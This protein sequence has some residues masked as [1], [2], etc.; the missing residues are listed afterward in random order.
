[1]KSILSLAT[2]LIVIAAYPAL[3]ERNL[4]PTIDSVSNI[5]P[6]RPEEPQ[7]MQEISIRDAYQ[8]VLVQD[9]YGAHSLAHV[10]EAGDCACGTRFPPWDSAEA[11][12]FDRFANAER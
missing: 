2:L 3:A 8:R 6:D 10:V 11:E 1:M 4:I 7:W 12:F 9:I 5:C